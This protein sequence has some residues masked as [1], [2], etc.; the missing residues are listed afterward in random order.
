MSDAKS[1]QPKL[2]CRNW[3]SGV[4]VPVE[5]MSTTTDTRALD[6]KDESGI[7]SRLGK[8]SDEGSSLLKGVTSKHGSN[9]D[10]CKFPTSAEEVTMQV[11]AGK[12]DCVTK[13]QEMGQN[14]F[15]ENTMQSVMETT[16]PPRDADRDRELLTGCLGKVFSEVVPVPIQHPA[17]GHVARQQKPWFFME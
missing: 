11:Q 6:I 2:T 10:A 8:N 4:L 15:D 14:A 12:D 3:E 13:A 17:P 9:F 1:R 5:M 7:K 16:K